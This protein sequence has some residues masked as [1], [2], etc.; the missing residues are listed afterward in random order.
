M[1]ARMNKAIIFVAVVGIVLSSLV[2][3][4][5]RNPQPPEFAKLAEEFVFTTLS[6]SPTAATG[7][8]LHTWTDPKTGKTINFDE[9]LDDNSAAEIAR[10]RA[11]YGDF[12][13]RLKAIPRV[14]LDPQTQVD[15]DLLTNGVGF[16]LYA[17][18][19]EQFYK[20]KPQN[21]A[22]NLGG[23]LFSPMSLEYADKNTRAGHLAARLERVPAFIEQAMTNLSASN[24]I[25]RKVALEATEGVVSLI[26]E[27]GPEFVKGT[28]SAERYEKAKQPA[29]DALAKYAEFVK[30]ELPKRTEFDWRLGKRRF[31]EKWKYYLQV[32]F[33]PDQMRTFAEKEMKETRAEMLRLAE[34]LAKQWFPGKTY[35]RKNPEAYLNAVVKD[36][37]G[38]IQEEKIGRDELVAQ[39]E[40]DV[41]EIN[42][43]IRK[44]GVLS[45]TD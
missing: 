13:A 2:P 29:L 9:L 16:A 19:D 36:V 3:A 38:K 44:K 31:A 7:A 42:D 1:V 5:A 21:Y 8:G 11:W 22:E 37:L 20:R 43:F 39:T 10:Q 26:T 4:D 27:L 25:Y 32:S 15:Y 6:F 14:S 30:N 17:Y 45:I 18:D 35:D 28:P 12:L 34:P 41:A 33:T 24:A 23:A 40:K